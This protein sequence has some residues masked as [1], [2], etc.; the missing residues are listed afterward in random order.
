M[1]F[2]VDALI[3]QLITAEWSHPC[4]VNILEKEVCEIQSDFEIQLKNYNYLKLKITEYYHYFKTKK[5]R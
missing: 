1:R 5:K 3:V 2:F 4:N